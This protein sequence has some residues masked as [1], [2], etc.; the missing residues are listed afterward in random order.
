MSSDTITLLIVDDE[1]E[2]REQLERLVSFEPDIE[3]IGK[4]SGGEQAIQ[5]ATDLKPD[6]IIMDINMPDLDGI[7]ATARITA[8]NAHIGVVILSAQNSPEH[9]RRATQAGA[10]D[11]LVKPPVLDELFD[12]IRKCHTSPKSQN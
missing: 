1:E 2:I 6:I 5:M 3:V 4:A 7:Q 9:I 10:C 8:A 12:T 11:Y